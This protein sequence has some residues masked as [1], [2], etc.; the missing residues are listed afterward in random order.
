MSVAIPESVRATRNALH[1]E[2]EKLLTEFFGRPQRIQ[3]LRRRRS[4]YSSSYTIQN[5]EIKLVNGRTLRLVLKDLSPTSLLKAARKVRP[6]FLYDPRREIAMYRTVLD[7]EQFGTALCYGAIERI[8]E[9]RYWLFLERV[10]G[11]LLWQVGRFEQWER[12][13]KWLAQFHSALSAKVAQGVVPSI[14]FRYDAEQCMR[15]ME[16]AVRFLTQRNGLLP[17]T[18][19]EQFRRLSRRYDNVIERLLSVAPTVIHGEFYPSNILLRGGAKGKQICPVDWE[20]SAIGPGFIDVAALASGAWSEDQK[21]RLV[22]T[23]HTEVK[24]AGGCPPPLEEFAR[25]V[26][27]G[28]LHLAVQWLG[29]ASDWT[30]PKSHERNWLHEALSLATRLKL[31]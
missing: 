30:P 19:A 26:D 6:E 20:V 8:E 17:P 5:I 22:K 24:L 25:L 10:E 27:Y 2:I 29:W 21:A 15:W 11:V 28:Q 13:A 3:S 16:R 12:A 18:M 4:R 14:V 7:P 23:Y 9:E 1:P 31:I